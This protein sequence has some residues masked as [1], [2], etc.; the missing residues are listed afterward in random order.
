MYKIEFYKTDSGNEPVREWL[1]N[2]P[3]EERKITGAE[4]M[5]VQMLYPD[6]GMPR[7]EPLGK[8]LSAV[9]VSLRDHW[10]R[11]LFTVRGKTIF[12]LHGVKKKT[13]KLDQKDINLA[14]ERMKGL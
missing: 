6:V 1:Q 8:K 10:I 2:L 12:L 4:L 3:K 14:M 13:N 9:R 5:H 7:V 11:V